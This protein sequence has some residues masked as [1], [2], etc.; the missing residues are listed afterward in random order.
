MAKSNAVTPTGRKRQYNWK[1]KMEMEDLG[2][3]QK[4]RWGRGWPRL[5]TN[6]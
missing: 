5:S 6:A 2:K 1:L 3:N 4:I